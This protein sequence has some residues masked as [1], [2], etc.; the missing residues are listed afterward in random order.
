VT[1]LRFAAPEAR[2]KFKMISER[3]CEAEA[4]KKMRRR[5]QNRPRAYDVKRYLKL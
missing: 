3:L 5:L 2:E 1:I 4:M